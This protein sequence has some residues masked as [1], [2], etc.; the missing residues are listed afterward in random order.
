MIENYDFLFF[1][2]VVVEYENFFYVGIVCPNNKNYGFFTNKK[3]EICIINYVNEKWE[4]ID[5]TKLDHV[6]INGVKFN[7]I[8]DEND[9]SI[10]FYIKNNEFKVARLYRNIENKK[11]IWISEDEVR[12]SKSKN[13]NNNLANYIVKK[14]NNQ[15]IIS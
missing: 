14:N 15:C 10:S 12:I 7:L 2:M 11:K 4:S 9:N 6:E 1:K 3:G 8:P 5:N 13:E